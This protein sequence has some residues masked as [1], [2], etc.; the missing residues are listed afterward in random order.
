MKNRCLLDWR[1]KSTRM[2]QTRRVGMQNEGVPNAPRFR[3][4]IVRFPLYRT[5]FV[6]P[7]DGAVPSQSRSLKLM[8]VRKILEPLLFGEWS[9]K[10]LVFIFLKDS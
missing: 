6:Q 3:S 10:E 7:S 8:R 2:A 5:D 4:T 1:G 9:L